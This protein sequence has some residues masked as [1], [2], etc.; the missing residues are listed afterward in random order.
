MGDMAGKPRSMKIVIT[1]QNSKL[2]LYG[3]AR[4]AAAAADLAKDMSTYDGV[5]YVQ[6]MEAVYKQGRKD[7]AAAAF[8]S[9]DKNVR[10]ARQGIPHRNPG[11]PK[12]DS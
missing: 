11:Q 10:A 2:T 5:K 6:I 8:D 1:L 7:G 12:K 9:I 3:G 4:I